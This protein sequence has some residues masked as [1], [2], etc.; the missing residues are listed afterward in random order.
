[1][2]TWSDLEALQI[3]RREESWRTLRRMRS[4]PPGATGP[5]DGRRRTFQAALEQAEQFLKAAASVGY[6]TKPVQVFYGLSQAGRAIAAASERLTD[7]EWRL[8]GHGLSSRNT[9]DQTDLRRVTVEAH[10]SGSP[11]AVARALGSE[12]P[13]HKCAVSLE[14]LWPLI[15]E[16]FEE[17]LPNGAADALERPALR[18]VSG[19]DRRTDSPWKRRHR[20]E[21]RTRCGSEG[22]S[23]SSQSGSRAIPPSLVGAGGTLRD[24]EVPGVTMEGNS[25]A[26]RLQGRRP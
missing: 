5:D 18:F 6:D 22:L 24:D 4:M 20:T 14:E 8:T 2:A 11:Q 3:S 25:L 15:P 26:I 21:C 10:K 7:D 23:R 9:R 19:T 16:T 1:M 17:R 13:P 12:F